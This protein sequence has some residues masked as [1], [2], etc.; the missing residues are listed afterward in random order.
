MHTN[1]C[2]LIEISMEI[3]MLNFWLP[4]LVTAQTKENYFSDLELII[5]GLHDFSTK[6]ENSSHSEVKTSPRS[7]PISQSSVTAPTASVS[8]ITSSEHSVQWD[9]KFFEVEYLKSY[10]TTTIKQNI[11]YASLEWINMKYYISLKHFN[12]NS[13]MVQKF[14]YNFVKCLNPMC[15]AV[16]IHWLYFIQKGTGCGR[17]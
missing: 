5:K 2:V 13:W 14:E 1:W 3:G 6:I 11:F 4:L 12:T 17:L 9:R 16:V 10:K 15:S 8:S 7:F